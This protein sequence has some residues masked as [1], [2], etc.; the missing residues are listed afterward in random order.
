MPVST[1][2]CIPG[3]MDLSRTLISGPNIFICQKA[4]VVSLEATIDDINTIRNNSSEGSV[5]PM[6]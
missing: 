5:L 1:Y 6:D 4:H 3:Q 2:K